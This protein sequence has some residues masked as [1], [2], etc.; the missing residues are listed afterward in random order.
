MG[1]LLA[2][3]SFATDYSAIVIQKIRYLE[4]DHFT[5]VVANCTVDKTVTWYLSI[6]A[7]LFLLVPP[8]DSFA[9]F[10]QR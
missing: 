10:S 5:I 4:L 7:F 8:L 6:D 9:M 3:W 2:R 1:F